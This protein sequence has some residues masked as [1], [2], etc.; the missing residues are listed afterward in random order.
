MPCSASMSVK[1]ARRS[2]YQVICC[3]Q[4]VEV[5][6]RDAVL[7]RQR[8]V[9]GVAVALEVVEQV[10][11]LVARD[12]VLRLLE[13]VRARVEALAGQ[14]A[15]ELVGAEVVRHHR[16]RQ[17]IRQHV[18]ARPAGRDVR[19]GHVDARIEPA[20]RRCRRA[21]DRSCTESPPARSSPR[22]SGDGKPYEL[23]NANSDAHK[24]WLFAVELR[25]R[26]DL[27]EAVAGVAE[28]HRRA[29][30]APEARGGPS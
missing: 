16:P 8:R 18:A 22:F 26:E 3:A 13:R 7:V 29:V 19:V 20:R 11:V 27:D 6:R 24:S 21:A 1:S 12:Q 15:D 17:R 2:T 4:H 5:A 10:E 28:L 30:V 23:W 25:R 14:V 9:E